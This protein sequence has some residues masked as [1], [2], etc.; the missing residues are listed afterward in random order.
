MSR[1]VYLEA[2]AKTQDVLTAK[3]MLRGSG[4]VVASTWHEEPVLASSGPHSHWTRQ[5]LEELKSCDTLVVVHSQEKQLPPEL[6]FT[7]GFASA[8]NL[9]VMW[10]GSPIELPGCFAKIHF[11]ATPDELRKH[12]Q[13]ENDLRLARVSDDLMAA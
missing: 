11:L 7:V 5:R 2:A 3:W 13:G 1:T 9:K 6:A 8:R 12:L 10:L 4:H